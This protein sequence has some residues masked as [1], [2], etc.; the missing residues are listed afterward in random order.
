M[1]KHQLGF[2]LCYYAPK[3]IRAAT[4]KKA[5]SSNKNLQ[6]Y[7]ASNKSRKIIRY[8]E[9][10]WK[11]LQC[12]I[13]NKPNL[14][15]LNF[16]G[17][18]IYWILRFIV[19]K[20]AIIVFDEFVSP[21]DSFVFERKKTNPDSMIAKILYQVE[22][23]ILD[24]SNYLLSDTR[25]QAEH[26]SELF[27]VPLEK[28]S[29]MNVTADEELFSPLA[30]PKEYKYPEIFNIFTYATFLPLHGMDT[31]LRAAKLLKDLP[32][33]FVIAGGKGKELDSFNALRHQLKLTKVT[34]IPWIEYSELPAFIRGAQLCLG[35]PFGGTSQ[36]GRVITGK[37]FQFLACGSPTVI[38]ENEET[39][40]FKDQQNCLLA[41]QSN[42]ESLAKAISWAYHNQEKLESIG[43]KGRILY[44]TYFSMKVL[45][46]RINLFMVDIS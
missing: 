19:G 33:R 2:V 36:A 9:S 4:L 31:I 16:R 25:S 30:Y 37:T 12:Q 41:S 24:D 28:F 44:E 13:K 40:F 46:N 21:Y 27:K 11:V 42:P 43:N 8:A 20:K 34:H 1:R 18:E 17:H 39:R 45:Q 23:S 6:L 7:D 14:W 35:G 3:Y 38:G 29:V 26:Y 32:I 22:K 5:L 15:I 10:L